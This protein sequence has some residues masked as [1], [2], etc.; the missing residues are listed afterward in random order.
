MNCYDKV[1]TL[2]KNMGLSENGFRLYEKA[3]IFQATRNPDNNYRVVKLEDA[4]ALTNGISYTRFGLSLKETA[5]VQNN[6]SLE[7]QLEVQDQLQLDLNQQM[8]NL[9]LLQRQLTANQKLLQQYLQ[10]PDLCSIIPTPKLWFLPAHAADMVTH[11]P[12]APDCEAWERKLP[13]V[14]SGYSV[15]LDDWEK[16]G[17]IFGPIASEEMALQLGLPLSHAQRFFGF[18]SKT[19]QMLILYPA[20]DV[21]PKE[22]QQRLSDFLKQNKLSAAGPIWGQQFNVVRRDDTLF[23]LDEILLPVEDK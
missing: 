13:F 7:E 17:L 8:T 11:E 10:S 16:S 19:I 4:C 21:F 20:A 5:E 18:G 3:G 1:S 12:G 15:A 23:R 22:Y 14:K 6:K 2:Q 9:L